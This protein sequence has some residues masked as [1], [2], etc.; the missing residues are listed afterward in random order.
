M[1]DRIN[2]YDNYIYKGDGELFCNNVIS[3]LSSCFYCSYVRAIDF[4][5]P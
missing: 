2:L 3:C 5:F 4:T 1:Y